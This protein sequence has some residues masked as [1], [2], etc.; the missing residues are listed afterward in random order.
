MDLKHLGHQSQDAVDELDLIAWEGRPITITLEATEFTSHCPVTRQP[1]FGRI[2]VEYVPGDHIIETKSWKLFL[3]QFR[4]RA[5][6]NEVIVNT[7]G[8]EIWS[9]AKPR[10]LRVTGM[11]NLRGGIGV[12]ACY[13]VDPEGLLPS[14]APARHPQG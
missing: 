1:D 4:E 3:W 9:Q 2:R 6:F 14:T 12:S 7:L 13:E 5:E 8:D 10:A 11:F